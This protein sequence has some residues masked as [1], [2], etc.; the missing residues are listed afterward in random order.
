[1]YECYNMNL[2]T[3]KTKIMRKKDTKRRKWIWYGYEGNDNV[4]MNWSF[5]A[6]N[7]VL[8]SLYL[9]SQ[10]LWLKEPNSTFFLLFDI[11]FFQVL[12]NVTPHL[13]KSHSVTI[14]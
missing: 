1:M 12:K 10:I 5:P 13:L 4:R 3:N 7:V 14:Y 6:L 2:I 9:G 11:Y 8:I